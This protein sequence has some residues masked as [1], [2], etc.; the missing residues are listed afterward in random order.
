[1][2]EVGLQVAI[3][4]TDAVSQNLRVSLIFGEGVSRP[5]LLEAQGVVRAFME[6]GNRGGFVRSEWHPSM[7]RLRVTDEWMPNKQSIAYRLQAE[8]FD[9]RALHVLQ[10]LALSLDKNVVHI[11]ELQIEDLSTDIIAARIELAVITWE[12][13]DILYPLLST[14]VGI[15]IEREEPADYRKNRRCVVEFSTEQSNEVIMN[16][17]SYIRDWATIVE[18][19]GFSPPVSRASDASVFLDTLAFYD[20]CSVELVFGVFDV[21]EESWRVLLNLLEAFSKNVAPIS[22]I[23]IE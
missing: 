14:Q 10:N 8:K 9:W 15:A 12:N 5:R 2:N 16:L 7:C 13:S 3:T 4:W 20:Q 23:T 21:S 17:I 11:K 1:M 18:Y 6:V 22:L 19:S